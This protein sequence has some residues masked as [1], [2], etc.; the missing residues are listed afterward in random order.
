MQI[1]F[2]R[3]LDDTIALCCRLFDL[4]ID[5]GGGSQL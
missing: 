4:D 1:K 2:D 3:I 5:L